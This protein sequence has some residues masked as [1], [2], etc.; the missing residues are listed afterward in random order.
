MHARPLLPIVFG[1]STGLQSKVKDYIYA[2]ARGV[3][4]ETRWGGGGMATG[5]VV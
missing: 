1:I 2:L 3:A 5:G 4:T